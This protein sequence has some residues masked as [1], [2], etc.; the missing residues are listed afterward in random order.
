ML[1]LVALI[2]ELVKRTKGALLEGA[3]N[4]LKANFLRE[5]DRLPGRGAGTAQAVTDGLKQTKSNGLLYNPSG[6]RYAKPTT[7]V[8]IWSS[9]SAVATYMPR[10][11]S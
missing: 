6:F 3:G 9:C 11:R 8:V 10:Y 4:S 5:S 1:D 7:L 2:Y